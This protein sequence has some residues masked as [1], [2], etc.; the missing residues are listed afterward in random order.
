MRELL[1]RPLANERVTAPP[2]LRWA[3]M[4]AATYYNVQL[5]RGDVKVLSVWPT[6]PRLQLA[7]RWVFEGTPRKLIPGIYRWYVWPGLGAK[8]E[9]RYGPMLGTRAFVVAAPPV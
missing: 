4:G 6:E 2:L 9:A 8:A 3:P 5:W 7:A 1:L